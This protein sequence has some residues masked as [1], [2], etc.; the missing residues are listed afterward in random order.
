MRRMV[1]AAAL[2]ALL[3]VSCKAEINLGVELNADGSGTL[4]AET[5][6]DEE[7]REFAFQGVDPEEAIFQDNDLAELEGAEFETY[8]EGEFTFY[9]VRA[10]FENID[11]VL[12]AAG[13]DAPVDQIQVTVTENEVRVTASTDESAGDLL[14]GEDIEGFSPDLLADT[15][16]IHLR[17]KMPGKVIEDNADRVLDDGSLEWDVPLTG[18]GLDVLA[19]SDPTAGDGGGLPLW[20][21]GGVAAGVVALGGAFVLMRRRSEATPD[22]VTEP[23]PVGAAVGAGMTGAAIGTAAAGTEPDL[24]PAPPVDPPPPP[25][26]EA[27]PESAGD[28]EDVPPP[29]T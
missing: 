13:E 27:D 1:L 16:A 18:Q 9:T 25:P 20:L 21:V 4:V 29:I 8:E 11:D 15:I 28:G 5:G 26:S 19:V 2:L 22:P 14:G 6:F 24:P 23:P 10:P 17:L 7:F 3:A 12:G